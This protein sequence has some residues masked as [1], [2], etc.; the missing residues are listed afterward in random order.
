MKGKSEFEPA[1]MDA[2]EPTT[3]IGLLATLNGQGLPHVTLITALQALTPRKLVWGQFTQGLSKQ[4]VL[5]DPRVGFLIMTMD[6][7]LWRGKARYDH[8]RREGPEYDMFNRKP[9]F[10]YNSYFGI[11]RVHYMDLVET[12]GCESLPLGRVVGSSLVTA[13]M[14]RAAATGKGQPIL[15]PW[16]TRLINRV[17]A[18]KFL[19]CRG[20]DGFPTIIP[21]L[22]CRAADARR[23]VFSPGCFGPELAALPDGGTVA[24]YI[25]VPTMETQLVRGVYHAGRRHLGFRLGTVEL[26]WVYNSM[27]PNHGPIYPDREPWH[28]PSRQV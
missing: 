6:R 27:P 22:Q 25:M 13:L 8:A 2:F 14:R 12:G 3:K 20:A 11:H 7:R 18:L 5:D 4:H 26:D 24:V 9:M 28:E 19:A 17:D 1:D 23:L 21:L 15:T 10:R 16:G